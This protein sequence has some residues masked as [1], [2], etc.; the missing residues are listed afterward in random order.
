V[1]G[2][3]GRSPDLFDIMTSVFSW[4]LFAHVIGIVFWMGGLLAA[5]QVLAGRRSESSA[6]SKA[7]LARSVRRLLK[8]FA[9]PGAAIAVLAGIVLLGA[10]QVDSQQ[11]WLHAKLACVVVL[12]AV[13]LLLTVSV[14]TMLS[15]GAEVS[16]LRLK[17]IPGAIVLLLLAIVFLAVIK[18]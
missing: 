8:A 9:H 3:F 11:A 12:I 1:A 10:K 18:P 15:G 4:A 13:D 5:V 2:S 6:Q 7:A 16:A 17:L 14:R